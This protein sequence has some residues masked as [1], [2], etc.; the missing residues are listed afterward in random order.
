MSRTTTVATLSELYAALKTAGGGDTILLKGGD[1]GNFELMAKSGFDYQFPS[2]VTIASADPAN[3]AV[4]SG[5]DVRD[6]K[7]LTFDSIKFDYTFKEG[8]P[9]WVK[10]FIFSN[11][12]NITIRNSVFDGDVAYNTSSEADGY[13]YGI[14]LVMRA[15]DG[16]TIENN[17]I[18]GFH[19]GLTM[20]SGDNAVIRGNEIHSIRSDGMNFSQ[21]QGILI[22]NNYIHDFENSE[23]SGDHSDMIQFWT[24]NTSEP[25]T[26]I[27]IRGNRLD[28]GEGDSTQSIFMR[29]DQ[30][31]RGLAGTEMYYQNVLIENNTITNAHAH[32]ISVGET[33]GLVIRNNSVLHSDGGAVDGADRSSEIPRINVAGS[34]TN[35][36]ISYNVT[37]AITG[38]SG[39]TGWFVKNN[40]FVQDQSPLDAGYYGNVFISSTLVPADGVHQF[41]GVPGGMIETL[42]A[43]STLTRDFDSMTKTLA[44]FQVTES[45]ISAAARLFDARD[46]IPNFDNLPVGTTFTWDFGDGTT[47]KGAAVS[48]IYATGGR[49]T[50]TLTVRTP[51]GQSDTQ[52]TRIDIAGADILSFDLKNGFTA[53]GYGEAEQLAIKTGSAGIALQGLGIAASV[54]RDHLTEILETDNFKIDLQIKASATSSQGEVFRL[55]QSF[56]A[57]VDK[58]GELNFL[59]FPKGEQM[60]TLKTT[61]AQLNDMKL[62]DISITF[63]EGILRATVDGVVLG[64]STMNSV[65]RADGEANL[66]FGTGSGSSNFASTISAFSI[67]IDEDDFQ[68][69]LAQTLPETGSSLFPREPAPGE[70]SVAGS[71]VHYA[72]GS[73]T[74]VSETSAPVPN[75][76]EVTNL[77]TAPSWSFEGTYGL[78]TASAINTSGSARLLTTGSDVDLEFGGGQGVAALGRL[79]AFEASDK[80][81]FSVDFQRNSTN[82]GDVRLVWNHL[83]LGLELVDDG[84]RVRVATAD[85][86]FKS[87]VVKNLGLQDLDAHNAVV[88]VDSKEDRLQVVLDDKVVLDV[89]DADF[90]IVGAGGRE[91]GW[92][93][94]SAWSDALNGRITDFDLG[95]RFDFLNTP[96]GLVA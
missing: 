24:N 52:G 87:F 42:G 8:T 40:A 2:S 44:H 5:V 31:D 46:T 69:G 89:K 65:L 45:P 70:E 56:I 3:P 51:D 88:M 62:H 6:A 20:G 82:D 11:S 72:P 21:M 61:G 85:D 86:G 15:C 27:I 12:E 1:Y 74:T 28:I 34:S 76:G 49:Y 48:H 41:I 91:W 92:K 18:F 96:D 73:E 63:D 29:N 39:Q 83:K 58:N 67:T 33:N 68:S 16:T 54:D 95:D 36:S 22:E 78:T 37:S 66:N 75:G 25:S 79:T 84:L 57:Q 17:E 43:G 80:L 93:L 35:V 55:H 32:G 64:Q 59:V 4:F 94:G 90:D 53:Y 50:A 23:G 77:T 14:G 26:D 10:P 13:G 30:V 60:V 7:N 9:L 38:P 81:G 19:R 71:L 47:G